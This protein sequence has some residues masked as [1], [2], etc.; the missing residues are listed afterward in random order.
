MA[1]RSISRPLQIACAAVVLTLCFAT[2]EFSMRYIDRP[3]DVYSGWRATGAPGPLNQ[4]G[5]RGRPWPVTKPGDFAVVLSGGD[6]VECRL[7]PEGETMD[8]ILEQALRRFN[9]DAQVVT[10]GAS[11]HGQD[12]ALL[13]LREHLARQR[14]DLVISWVSA[15][16]DVPRNTFR[17]GQPVPGI[18]RLKPTFALVGGDLRGPSEAL[19]QSL[20]SLK[21]A[22]LLVPLFSDPEA[23]W[24]RYLPPASPGAPAAVAGIERRLHVDD[25]LDQQRSPWS[26]W[27]SPR[28]AR[29]A[30]G[31]D[32]T[33][34]LL[35][36]TGELA[37]LH[38]ARFVVLLAPRAPSVPGA[39]PAVDQPAGPL[40][41][42]HGGRWFLA[43]PKSRDQAM[44]DIG[45]GFSPVVLPPDDGPTSTPEWQRRI[46]TRLAEVLAQRALLTSP[47]PA[48]LG[49]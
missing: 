19:G 20:Y 44:A 32:L 47:P 46:A 25:P 10:L 37:Q 12:Q 42:E 30:Y 35:R 8:A 22:A 43:D 48:R 13:L 28:P 15:D 31:I 17:S 2:G 39:G 23:R 1:Q 34:H 21:F 3:A 26:V 24:S 14:A 27:L 33:R 11:G 40:A 49:R 5:L 29:V 18:D 38:G 41:L 4:A 45:D 36:R 9:R 6:E 7:C 16:T